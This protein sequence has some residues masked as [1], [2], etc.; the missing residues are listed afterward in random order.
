MIKE[1]YIRNLLET[2]LGFIDK[3]IDLICKSFNAEEGKFNLK[4][5]F[6]YENDDIK[7]YDNILNDEIIPKI[8]NKIKRSQ[9]NSYKEYKLKIFN[10]VDYLDICELFSK[11]NT[12]YNI[13]LYNCLLLMKNEQ[14]FFTDKF[15]T[16][17]NLK[18]EFTFKTKDFLFFLKGKSSFN[19]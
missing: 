13:S 17:T 9:I 8:R 5:L 10:N 1:N 14:F 18:D 19:S 2:K 4:K 16:E 6:L 12:L 11:F 7:K 15:F 3:D